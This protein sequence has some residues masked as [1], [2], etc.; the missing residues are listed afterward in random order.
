MVCISLNSSGVS[1]RSPI[2]SNPKSPVSK[3]ALMDQTSPPKGET[4]EKTEKVS[5]IAIGTIRM[6]HNVCSGV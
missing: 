6:G 3:S 4:K 5:T 2:G 1:G